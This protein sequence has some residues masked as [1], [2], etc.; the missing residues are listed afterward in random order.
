MTEDATPTEA[1][2]TR[3]ARRRGLPPI[4][5]LALVAVVIAVF[6]DPISSIAAAV[7]VLLLAPMAQQGLVDY[8]GVTALLAKIASVFR[9]P[10]QP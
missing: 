6:G 1:Q 2:P 4:A 7:I 9:E 5:G 10:P 3:P 8:S